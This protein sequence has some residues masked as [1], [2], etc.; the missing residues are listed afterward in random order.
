MSR[1][2]DASSP[3]GAEEEGPRQGGGGGA[4]RERARVYGFFSAVFAREPTKEAIEAFR[5]GEVAARHEGLGA[6]DALRAPLAA[7]QGIPRLQCL[8]EVQVRGLGPAR[9][10][11]LPA[12]RLDVPARKGHQ[13]LRDGAAL[14]GGEL[15]LPG[16][17]RHT[18][19]G[20]GLGGVLPAA[21]GGAPGKASTMERV[22]LIGGG[23]A[24]WDA[25]WQVES[26]GGGEGDVAALTAREVEVTESGGAH[27]TVNA[28][29]AVRG[30]ASGGADIT[31]LGDPSTIDVSTSGGADVRTG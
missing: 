8:S 14:P 22:R 29:G 10:R 18:R 11:D 30:S 9:E 25:V 17:A 19:G 27:V 12:L 5:A 20:T 26:L 28:S 6:T 15:R 23:V 16:A 3:G 4:L 2:F 31:I 24:G 1:R 7:W 13:A 21:A